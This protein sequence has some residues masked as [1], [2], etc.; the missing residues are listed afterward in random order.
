MKRLFTTAAFLCMVLFLSACAKSEYK[1]LPINEE[2]DICVICNMQV[3]DDA[4]AV[5]LTTKEGKNFKFDDLGCMN[6]WKQKNSVDSIGAQFVRDYNTKDW[7]KF[8]EASYVFHPSFKT[9]MAYGI[10][11][12]KNKG[13]AE[14]FIDSQKKGKLMTVAEL[15]THTWERSSNT[16]HMDMDGAHKMQDSPTKKPEARNTD[17]GMHGK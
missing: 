5:Q 1:A 3:K 14:A 7:I 16:M 11:S 17:K 15:S 10:Y 2:V 8:E 13:D 6:E 9:P 12:F 4:Y